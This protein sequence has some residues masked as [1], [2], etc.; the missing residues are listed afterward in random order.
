[1]NGQ[2]LPDSL[3]VKNT[4][5]DV[6]TDYVE[7]DTE[8]PFYDTAFR[9]KRQYS[10]P[11]PNM[12][13][14]LSTMSTGRQISG[15]R[16]VSG[17]TDPHA[18]I[19][20]LG[21]GL[22]EEEDEDDLNDERDEPEKEIEPA[23]IQSTATEAD[24]F[25]SSP[26][27]GRQVTE[28]MW[29]TW[30]NTAH[31]NALA[32]V[33]AAAYL[34]AGMDDR[35]LDRPSPFGFGA[36]SRLDEQEI[37]EP[38][39]NEAQ[40]TAFQGLGAF[41]GD[42]APQ[43]WRS[44]TTVMLRN[45]P[46]KYNQ[47]MLLEELNSSGFL[48][49]FDFLYLPIDPETNANRGYCFINFTDPSFAWMLKMTYEGRKMG[50]FNSDKVVSVAPAALQGFEANF[51]HYS[52]SRVNRGDP[53]TRPLFLRESSMPTTKQDSRRRGGRRSQCSLI[54]IAARQQVTRQEPDGLPLAA[55]YV[56]LQGPAM[57]GVIT[58]GYGKKAPLASG[59]KGAGKMASE[60]GRITPPSGSAEGAA[61]KPRFCPFCGNACQPEFR[62]CQF[63]GA[64]L[65][66]SAMTG[67]PI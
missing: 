22:L 9:N 19:S 64:A 3:K 15:G 8:D 2:P 35:L 34:G 43:E 16:Q 31:T 13:R 12:P 38:L 57:P 51:A 5:I 25:L 61:V 42:E 14:Q 59:G 10:E 62:F 28:Q 53:S 39:W 60:P 24:D 44:K 20:V 36:G 30:R 6:H 21:P 52:T 47:Q 32:S 37:D 66:F 50:R 27:M 58:G 17:G 41:A 11:A 55:S 1:M 18:P 4:F 7:E 49:T 45:L 23:W 40:R 56:G 46:N 65:N 67:A 48:G 29:P 63:C 33:A 54:D 26:M